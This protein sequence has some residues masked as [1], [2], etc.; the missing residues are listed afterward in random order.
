MCFNLPVYHLTFHRRYHLHHLLQIY[1][2]MFLFTPVQRAHT[3]SYLYIHVLIYLYIT[4]HITESII[5]HTSSR[6]INTGLIYLY[7]FPTPPP[8]YRYKF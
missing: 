8:I 2:Y 3:S 6:S 1:R 4:S 5:C 7:N